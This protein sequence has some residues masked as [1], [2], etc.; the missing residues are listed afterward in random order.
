MKEKPPAVARVRK[1]WPRMPRSGRTREETLF[2]QKLRREVSRTEKKLWPA[3]LDGQLGASFRRQH[4]IDGLFPDYC[5]VALRLIVEVDGPEH[6]L[7][8]DANRDARSK[9]LGYDVLRFA[10]QDIDRNL[11]G[12]I[13]TIYDAVQLRLMAAA[14]PDR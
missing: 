2:A 6:D 8:Q 3:L 9:A 1:S 14:A 4:V 7:V 5:C 11:D 12:V 13:S 10:V